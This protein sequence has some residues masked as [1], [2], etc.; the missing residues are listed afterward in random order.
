MKFS[1]IS[2]SRQREVCGD[3]KHRSSHHLHLRIAQ[4]T[5]QGDASW[6]EERSDDVQIAVNKARKLKEAGAI[7]FRVSHNCEL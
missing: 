3:V 1:F 7:M 6:E 5:K 4:D 2:G